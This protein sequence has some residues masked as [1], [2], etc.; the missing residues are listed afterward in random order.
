MRL[1]PPPNV[2]YTLSDISFDVETLRLLLLQMLIRSNVSVGSMIKAWDVSGDG[3]LSLR[4]FSKEVHRSF[5]DERNG[6]KLWDEVYPVV[7]DA[8]KEV[9]LAVKHGGKSSLVMGTIDV[10]E[11]ERWLNK[12][13]D[14]PL[15]ERIRLK[16]SKTKSKMTHSPRMVRP[17]PQIRSRVSAMGDD[18]AADQP[19]DVADGAT[20][21]S[22]MRAIV[23]RGPGC[24]RKPCRALVPK[25]STWDV[26]SAL[27]PLPQLSQSGGVQRTG[28]VRYARPP[29]TPRT[30]RSG[31]PLW[32]QYY[33][34]T[35]KIQAGAWSPRMPTVTQADGG[36]FSSARRRST[37]QQN[38]L[39]YQVPS[40]TN[41]ETWRRTPLEL[42]WPS[43]YRS[44]FRPLAQVGS[45]REREEW[46]GG[47]STPRAACQIW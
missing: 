29:R 40:R 20:S 19:I 46:L 12:P 39:Y 5:A 45:I 9:D 42:C 27:P 10:I 13:S 25:R 44:M 41:E 2:S 24:E 4:E 37:A 22:S 16:A 11:L 8:F 28:L 30:P 33:A 36:G 14:G 3:E 23:E 26:P 38:W 1:Q 43:G 31:S 7:C 21:P 47:T 34:D 18:D 32:C 35:R 15:E 17:P 6:A